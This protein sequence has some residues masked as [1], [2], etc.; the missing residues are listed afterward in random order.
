MSQIKNIIVSAYACEP[1]KGSEPGIGWHWVVELARLGYNVNVITRANNQETITEGLRK[2]ETL[3]NLCFYYYDLPKWLKLTKKLPFGIYFYYFFWQLGIVSLAKKITINKKIDLIH[4]ITF[5]VFRHAS[6]LWKLNTPFV[7]GPVG[8]GEMAPNRLLK[9][10][11]LV[12][13]IK[14]C[15][16]VF[17]NYFFKQSPSL[18]RMLKKTDLILC[19]TEDTLKFLPKKYA[20][21][22]HVEMDI[23]TTGVNKKVEESVKNE[24][25]KV[26][27]VGRFLGWKGIH[28]SIDAINKANSK[29]ENVD[30][31][32]I[33]KGPF[34]LFLEK[35]VKSKSINFVDWVTQEELFNYY[36]SF[37][38]FLFPSFHD[39]SGSVILE[40]YSFGLPVI[41]LNL[42][43]PD[44]LVQ[45]DCGFKIII[46]NKTADQ[47]ST[48]IANLLLELN[49]DKSKLAP[50]KESAFSKAEYY[51]W[52]NTVKRT[53]KLIEDKVFQ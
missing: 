6:F 1:N 44:K 9:T 31:T 2:I 27:Y 29:S 28:L 42:G 32:L 16:R 21:K 30:F 22:M 8:G 7:F 37:D 50:L 43:G 25:L 53:Y 24:N 52:S 26:L 19:K 36:S 4:H 14:E 12:E 46:E 17:A 45:S 49:N 38:C 48:E 35:R 39:S 3:N 40:A 18:N 15:I 33:G 47:I 51:K 5:G 13:Y 41:S 20:N 10:L 23:G 34:K 11:P